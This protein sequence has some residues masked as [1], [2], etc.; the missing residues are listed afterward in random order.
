MRSKQDFK[1]EISFIMTTFLKLLK[2]SNTGFAVTRDGTFIFFDQL[3]G[4]ELYI[5]K[6]NLTD[7]Y[8]DI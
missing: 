5:Q 2:E 4:E 7:L 1:A 8:E 3:T 6:Q